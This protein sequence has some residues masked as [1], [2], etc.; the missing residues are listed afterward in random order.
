MAPKQSSSGYSDFFSSGLRE[1]VGRARL[2]IRPGTTRRRESYISFTEADT[3][4]VVAPIPK[5]PTHRRAVSLMNPATI[6]MPSNS[7]T[8]TATATDLPRKRTHRHSSIFGKSRPISPSLEEEVSF[9]TMNS[10]R[11]GR[12][13]KNGH[14]DGAPPIFSDHADIW[15][16]KARS[17]PQ[18]TM[19][20]GTGR[21]RVV[22]VYPYATCSLPILINP[23][24]LSVDNYALDTIDPFAASRDSKSFFIDLA[25]RRSHS[26]VAPQRST[27]RNSFLSLTSS[28]DHPLFS[29]LRV[30]SSSSS[31]SPSESRRKH[32]RVSSETSDRP[33]WI[34]EEEE[35]PC[36]RPESVCTEDYELNDPA[37]IDWRQFHIDVLNG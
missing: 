17:A 20:T 13:S 19:G 31:S 30:A 14:Q 8:P 11:W 36:S 27:R 32:G 15:S 10:T 29:F 22:C 25:G 21:M 34:L 18:S 7:S 33:N 4:P 6:S 23:S 12:G 26:P 16:R 9:N 28:K 35:E 37:T 5:R 2:R 24:I 1:M 3:L